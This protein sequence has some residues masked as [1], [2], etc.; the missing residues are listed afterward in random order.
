MYIYRRVFYQ[1]KLVS[2]ISANFNCNYQYFSH[3]S[4]RTNCLSFIMQIVDHCLHFQFSVSENSLNFTLWSADHCDNI[5][6]RPMK[7]CVTC[8]SRLR[9]N[10]VKGIHI[11][12][13]FAISKEHLLIVHHFEIKTVLYIIPSKLSLLKS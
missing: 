10:D 1:V 8:E 9:F 11:A 13:Q 4:I 6:N 7:I 3:F 12:W 2:K 5:T